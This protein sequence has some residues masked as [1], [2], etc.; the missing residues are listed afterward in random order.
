MLFDWAGTII[1]FGCMAPL[2]AFR[3]AFEACGI[4]LTDAQIRAPMGSAKRDHIL[5]ILSDPEVHALWIEQ[6]GAEPV[7]ADIDR[8]YAAFLAADEAVATDYCDLVPG[9]QMTIEA[10]GELGILIGGTTGYPRAIIDRI[11]PVVAAQ[12]IRFASSVTAS[13]VEH[14]RPAPDMCRLAAERLGV[15]EPASCVVVDDTLAGIAAGRSAGMWSVGVAASGNELG[16]PL[17]VW[18]A[19]PVREREQRLGPIRER[20]RDA[21][22]HFVIDTVLDLG[23]TIDIINGRLAMGRRP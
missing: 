10:L 17:G 15:A 8:L 1:D 11:A 21:G 3:Q 7:S 4:A 9:V 19:M 12:G 20:M 5:R 2:C 18:Q 23:T 13:D 14:G 16:L 22:A 6:N